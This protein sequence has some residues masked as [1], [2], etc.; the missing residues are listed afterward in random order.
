MSSFA[1]AIQ[2]AFAGLQAVAGLQITYATPAGNVGL[3]AVPGQSTFEIAD[4][5]G[6]I[7][8]SQS[9]DYILLA[10]E[11]VIGGAAVIPARGHSVTEIAGDGFTYV[12]EVNRPDGGEQPWRYSDSSRQRLRVHTRL[13]SKAA[14]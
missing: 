4:A 7:I 8:E 3:R 14:T 11:L 12:Y 6:G 9:R 10:S 5:D 13:K 2:Q 1:T